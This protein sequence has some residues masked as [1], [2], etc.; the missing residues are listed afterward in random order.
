MIFK[1]V[2]DSL[3]L[4]TKFVVSI[5]ALLITTIISFSTYLSKKQ[6]DGFRRELENT[7]ETMIRMLAINVEYGV[8]F[9]SKRDIEDALEILW[10]FEYVKYAVVSNYSGKNLAT[11]GD[12][13]GI[14]HRIRSI[15]KIDDDHVEFC[16]DYYV[17]DSKGEEF[18]ELN[19]PVLS[20]HKDLDREVLGI[21]AGFGDHLQINTTT[22]QIGKVKVII[23]LA[24]VNAAIADA[25]NT[26]I[27]L[28]II[29]S[30]ITMVVLTFFIRIITKPIRLMVKATD[31]IAK[32]EL[33]H[34][35]SIKQQDEI[36]QLAETFNKMVESLKESRDE[37]DSYNKM[38]EGTIQVRTKELEA[39]Q[40]Q[41]VQSEKLSAIGQ[42]AAG[43]AHELNN[44]LGGILGYAQFTL[45]KLKK[46]SSEKL[47]KKEFENYKRYISDIEKQARRCRDIVQ[48]LLRFS[49]STK[50]VEFEEVDLNILI[51]ETCTFIEHQLSM[52]QIELRLNL[53]SN[54]PNVQG[55][56]G[57]LQQVFTNIIL[58]AMQ[59]SPPNT[60]IEVESKFSP[61]LGQFNGTVEL[62]F[63]D[64]GHGIREAEINK[65]FEPFFTT[66]EV[67]KGTG[68]GLSVSYGIIKEH[69]GEIKVES[70]EGLGTTF[71]IIIPL[72]NNEIK[73]DKTNKQYAEQMQ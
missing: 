47:T 43:V 9:E 21:T 12:E 18:I 52:K 4:R 41:L 8:L 7:S 19:Y 3:N 39:T 63:S 50:K 10:Q 46:S 32:G 70:Q 23:S 72:Q 28:S 54:L 29:V 35:V 53:D 14:F 49:R 66:K 27:L 48:N 17:V 38:L 31:K 20:N 44:P 30:I 42:L 57:Q 6:A 25:R 1:K 59:A 56:P 33:D 16:E 67:G 62:L 40:A 13:I 5:S 71:T 15:D 11:I 34:H 24:S 36:G 68:L 64:Q 58:N 73:S 65:I 51:A 26:A 61:P 55:N 60:F 2:F 37:V 69:G 22:E 45:E